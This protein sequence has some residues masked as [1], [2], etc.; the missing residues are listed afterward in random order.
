MSTPRTGP[1][2]HIEAMQSAMSDPKVVA[3]VQ[4]ALAPY[5]PVIAAL[6]K[7]IDD[8]DDHRVA[9]IY[10]DIGSNLCDLLDLLDVPY[11][12]SLGMLILQ[13]L[14][15]RMARSPEKWSRYTEEIAPAVNR[16]RLT[17]S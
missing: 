13:Q 6:E 10:R 3:E 16:R 8:N 9:D 17:P 1:P 14:G 5:M 4:S 15:G 2:D 12:P 7:M 11:D